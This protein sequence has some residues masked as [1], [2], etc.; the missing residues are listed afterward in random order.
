MNVHET[1][2]GHLDRSIEGVRLVRALAARLDR[3]FKRAD[4]GSARAA[5]WLGVPE[6][7]VQYWPQGITVP[8][9]NACM[10]LAADLNLDGHWLCTGQATVID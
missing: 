6:Y 7:D 1:N 2:I 3:A 5:T 9:L 8:P 4:I 10:R